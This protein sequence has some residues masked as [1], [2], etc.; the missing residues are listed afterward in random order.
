MAFSATDAA[1]EGFRVVR[2]HP[3]ALIFWALFYAV[4]MI[5]AL[6]LVG[7]SIIGLMN[8]AEGLESSGATSPRLAS[9]V[10]SRSKT[11][12]P[13]YRFPFPP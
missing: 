11:G 4:M 1:F 12:P 8:A 6:A 13:G 10:A 9:D 2:R 5:A 3:M 7:G